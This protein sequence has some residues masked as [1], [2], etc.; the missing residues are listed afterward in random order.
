[1]PS[2]LVGILNRLGYEAHEDDVSAVNWQ[3]YNDQKTEDSH[4]ENRGEIELEAKPKVKEPAMEVST[5]AG[6]MDQSG[7]FFPLDGNAYTHSAAARVHHNSSYEKLLDEGWTRVDEGGVE[8]R[9][10][11]KISD[12]QWTEIENLL[13][14]RGEIVVNAGRIVIPVEVSDLTDAGM[15]LQEYVKSWKGLASTVGSKKQAMVDAWLEKKA[16]DPVKKTVDVNGIKIKIEWPIGSTR[17]YE[18]DTIT[19]KMRSDYGYLPKSTGDDGE[20]I[21]VY[22]GPNH[23]SKKVFVVQQLKKGTQEPDEEKYMLGYDSSEEAKKSYLDHMPDEFFGSIKEIS[24]DEFAKMVKQEQK[25]EADSQVNKVIDMNGISFDIEESKGSTDYGFVPA[26]LGKDGQS[27]DVLIG[28]DHASQKVFKIEQLNKHDEVKDYKYVLGTNSEKEAEELYEKHFSSKRQGDI[29]EMSWDQFSSLIKKEQN[30]EASYFLSKVASQLTSIAGSPDTPKYASAH[31]FP[32]KLIVLEGLDGSGKSSNLSMLKT[33]L[34]LEGHDVVVTAWNSSKLVSDLVKEAK[35]AKLLTPVSFSLLHAT[36]LA[37]RMKD[38]IVPALKKGS[39]VLADRYFPTAFARDSVRG[40]DSAW[41]R[42]VYAFAVKPDAIIY[43]DLPVKDAVERV[44]A[45]KASTSLHDTSSEVATSD[46]ALSMSEDY[47]VQ[48]FRVGNPKYYEGG[49]DLKLSDDPIKNFHKFQEKVAEKYVAMSEEFGFKKIQANQDK[50]SVHKAIMATVLPVVGQAKLSTITCL[51]GTAHDNGDATHGGTVEASLNKES[52]NT[53]LTPEEQLHYAV[54]LLEHNFKN[55][56]GQPDFFRDDKERNYYSGLTTKEP[57]GIPCSVWIRAW[58]KVFGESP[59]LSVDEPN[60]EDFMREIHSKESSLSKEATVIERMIDGVKTK[61]TVQPVY[62]LESENV[63]SYNVYDESGVKMMTVPNPTGQLL[64]AVELDSLVYEELGKMKGRASMTSTAEKCLSCGEEFEPDPVFEKAHTDPLYGEKDVHVPKNCPK[65]RAKFLKELKDESEKSAGD[66]TCWKCAGEGRIGD[67]YSDDPDESDTCPVC[68]GKGILKDESKK[69]A[70]LDSRKVVQDRMDLDLRRKADRGYKGKVIYEIRPE[71]VGTTFQ[72][73]LFDDK[74]IGEYEYLFGHFG[75]I[76]PGD[77]GKFLIVDK[78]P[79]SGREI[80]TME[81]S[82]QRDRRVGR[83]ASLLTEEPVEA[84]QQTH[85]PECDGLKQST[86]VRGRY[87]LCGNIFEIK[88][89]SGE[90]QLSRT[91][92]GAKALVARAGSYS[93]A[94]DFVNALMENVGNVHEAVLEKSADLAMNLTDDQISMMAST[95]MASGWG[96]ETALYE[97]RQLMTVGMDEWMAGKDKDTVMDVKEALE[98][99]ESR[100]T[101]SEP[102]PTIYEEQGS[103]GDGKPG[104][105]K[106]PTMPNIE[107]TKKIGFNQ[108]QRSMLSLANEWY[109]EGAKMFLSEVFNGKPLDSISSDEKKFLVDFLSHPRNS[110]TTVSHNILEQLSGVKEAAKEE[111]PTYYFSFIRGYDGLAGTAKV[112]TNS[113]AVPPDAT[114]VATFEDRGAAAQKLL[115][116]QAQGHTVEWDVPLPQTVE[117]AKRIDDVHSYIGNGKFYCKGQNTAFEAKQAIQ[118]DEAG[119]PTYKCP[120]DDAPLPAREVL[121]AEY[122]KEGAEEEPEE[123]GDDEPSEG[124]VI[125]QD[126]RG[127]PSGTSAWE[128]GG[129]RIAVLDAD[130]DWDKFYKEIYRWMTKHNVFPSVWTLSDHGNYHLVTDWKF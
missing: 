18:N 85:I 95:L 53:D 101:A 123:F 100:T 102:S 33:A 107:A 36:D 76:M 72:G 104:S 34:E 66:T 41:L 98:K 122:K 78:D 11:S 38:V 113:D 49:L 91:V 28:N 35:K 12:A 46:E 51:C 114:E 70:G 47:Q 22:V 31:G 42:N 4:K 58:E 108:I 103:V 126:E 19:T 25:K 16:N 80:G 60:D 20:E 73:R 75:K 120:F 110:G 62:G 44:L 50:V 77:V 30:R 26:V 27:L 92:E 125:I 32:G 121:D 15:N 97:V 105:L 109:G 124:D 74:Q 61:L 112:T 87:D 68:E 93:T 13:M 1:M 7:Q 79:V 89:G 59:S 82:E 67:I 54:Y 40:M 128:M 127:T 84:E 57:H 119:K 10:V 116:Y 39:I 115:D 111:K 6:W 90:W 64:S 29:T 63:E 71:D 52:A 23:S 81:S 65:C 43:L 56:A 3:E 69:S 94:S 55:S 117:A 2:L 83:T 129:D 8:V 14:T 17:T 106:T 86:L 5:S 118:K 9:D 21:D 99:M 45:R 88:V 96:K 48:D 37:E 130:G 24:W